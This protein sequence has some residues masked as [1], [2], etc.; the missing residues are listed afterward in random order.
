MTLATV[1]SVERLR[2]KRYSPGNIK[3]DGLVSSLGFI[4]TIFLVALFHR[5]SNHVDTVLANELV[6]ATFVV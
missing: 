6:S 2:A 4:G 1:G 5:R 3:I